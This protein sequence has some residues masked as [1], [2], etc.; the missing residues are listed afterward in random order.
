[1]QVG[2][3]YW[4]AS[5][6]R[7]CLCSSMQMLCVTACDA[8]HSL[9]KLWSHACWRLLTTMPSF[10]K[11]T[12]SR[13]LMLHSCVCCTC[14]VACH[15][16]TDDHACRWSEVEATL[17]DARQ[18]NSKQHPRLPRCVAMIFTGVSS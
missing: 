4:I 13:S 14:C 10:A 5:Q 16:L 15:S 6:A 3:L 18:M 7:A 11:L 12:C 1:V 2:S 9:L 8:V 17:A